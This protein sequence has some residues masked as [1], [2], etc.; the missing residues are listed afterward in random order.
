MEQEGFQEQGIAFW[1]TT[2]VVACTNKA[3]LR[4]YF[5]QLPVL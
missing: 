4:R 1:L 2:Q 5:L 3:L